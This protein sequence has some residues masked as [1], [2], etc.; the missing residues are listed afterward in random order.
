MMQMCDVRHENTV[1]LRGRLWGT[2]EWGEAHAYIEAAANDVA[3]DCL[4]FPGCPLHY[5]QNW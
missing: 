2:G 5:N 3:S 1:C 4:T